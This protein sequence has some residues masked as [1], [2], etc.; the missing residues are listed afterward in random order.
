[1]AA[2]EVHVKH[3]GSFWVVGIYRAY[4]PEWQLYEDSI[5]TRVDALVTA[6]GLAQGIAGREGSAISVHADNPETGVQLLGSGTSKTLEKIVCAD[7]TEYDKR[8]VY[9]VKMQ[10]TVIEEVEFYVEA[11]S[12]HDILDRDARATLVA[13]ADNCEYWDGDTVGVESVVRVNADV[14][15]GGSGVLRLRKEEK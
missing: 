9:L 7:G 4:K 1:M 11:D 3:R 13:H 6:C 2:V 10:R 12:V 8:K 5:P 14:D 15:P